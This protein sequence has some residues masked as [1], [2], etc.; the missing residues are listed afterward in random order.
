M[1]ENTKM[2][3][4]LY[5]VTKGATTIWE[6]WLGI[7]DNNVPRDSQNQYT[8]GSVVA[9]LFSHCAGIRPAKPGFR[10][11]RIEPMPGG[12]LKFA[13]VEYESTQGKISSFWEKKDGEFI[14]RID[15]PE[16]ITC[17][18]I[19]PDGTA[20]ETIGGPQEYKCWIDV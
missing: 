9:W 12:T 4:W 7:D 18:V 6:N 1:L 15:T 16:G 10:E 14:L 8:S 20:Y 19:M 5:P 13:K 17:K 3:G 11:I 2:P